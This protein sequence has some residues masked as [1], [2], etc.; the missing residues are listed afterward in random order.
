M[1]KYII[2]LRVNTGLFMF[3]FTVSGGCTFV[4]ST[5]LTRIR[6]VF[7][8]HTSVLFVSPAATMEKRNVKV[9]ETS[10]AGDS[11]HGR[12]ELRL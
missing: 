11:Q 8:I 2:R 5:T 7:K 6:T 1:Q 9:S 10:L 12:A 3:Q 4:K